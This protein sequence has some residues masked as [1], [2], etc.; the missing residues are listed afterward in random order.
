MLL[1]RQAIFSTDIFTCFRLKRAEDSTI[2]PGI[3]GIGL[4]LYH[5][6]VSLLFPVLF[7]VLLFPQSSSL[8]CFPYSFRFLFSVR[9]SARALCVF[10]LRSDPYTRSIVVSYKAEGRAKSWLWTEVVLAD[11]ETMAVGGIVCTMGGKRCWF[12]KMNMGRVGGRTF[13]R[14]AVGKREVNGFHLERGGFFVSMEP[15]AKAS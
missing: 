11:G 4:E 2:P 3:I 6:P 13:L 9:H 7:L 10:P 15:V 5:C 14:N 12:P 1:N 8:C